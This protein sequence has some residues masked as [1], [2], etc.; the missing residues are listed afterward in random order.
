MTIGVVAN[1]SFNIFNFRLPLMQF[2]KSKGYKIIAI[3]PKD[4]FT[5]K[6]IE[7]GFEFIEITTLS[8]KGTNPIQDLKL[9]FELRKLYKANKID[10]VLQYT[11]KPNIYGS[12]AAKLAGI[13]SVSTV[14]GLGYTFLSSGIA[15]IVSKW[16][17]R[18]AFY[19]SDVVLFQ[20][21]D[22]KN[23]FQQLKLVAPQKAAIIPGS[24]IDINKFNISFCNNEPPTH[25]D[26]FL[27]IGRLLKDKGFFEYIEAAKNT[28]QKF[29][30]TKFLIVGELDK[31]NPSSISKDE[32]DKIT[33]LQNIE[34]LGFLPDTRVA[35]CQSTCVVLPS[36]R[37]GLPRVILEGMAM[38]KPCI[39]TNVAGCRDAVDESCALLAE[40]TDSK[41]LQLQMEKFILL[42]KNVKQ[43]MGKNARLRAEQVFAYEIIANNYL[44]IILKLVNK[45]QEI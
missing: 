28:L 37:E 34:Y 26:V 11:I 27:F 18:T 35:I 38:S 24:G 4:N 8:R 10:V 43:Q 20:N 31:D 6:I 14:T 39:T 21:N 2:L 16:L 5:P 36:Y 44:K 15:A 9:I 42:D 40:V 7:A 13:K 25:A 32:L 29:P 22:D 23:L 19:F 3:A 12:F 41:D 45:N 17:Y 30:Q 33:Q 1:A